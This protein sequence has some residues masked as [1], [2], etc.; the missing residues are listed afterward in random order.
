MSEYILG[1]WFAV[2][3][4]FFKLVLFLLYFWQQNIVVGASNDLYLHL[5]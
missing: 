4:I 1:I 5:P 3:Y 2:F